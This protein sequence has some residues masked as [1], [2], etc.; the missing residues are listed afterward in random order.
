[1]LTQHLNMPV[2]M[3]A[4][5]TIPLTLGIPANAQTLTGLHAKIQLGNKTC[6]ASHEH[7][8]FAKLAANKR[9]TVQAAVRDWTSFTK[10]EYG[11]RWA[12]FRNS[13]RRRMACSKQGNSWSCK[14]VA[15]PCRG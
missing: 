8:G 6:F 7:T 4:F 10:L 2:L 1:M 15:S 13:H 14:V 11:A 5:T 3:L 12:N 9:A